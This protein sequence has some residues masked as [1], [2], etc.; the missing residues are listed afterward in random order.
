[1]A[2]SA[3]SR[4][5]AATD[6]RSGESSSITSSRSRSVGSRPSITSDFAAA[7]TTR[8]KP[9][10]SSERNSWKPGARPAAGEKRADLRT[11]EPS[12]PRHFAPA[13]DTHDYGRLSLEA[14]S[15]LAERHA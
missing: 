3:P 10:A 4:E 7:L 12:R 13:E 9:T 14:V 11:F 15:I 2:A 8:W 5:R 6:A 1:M